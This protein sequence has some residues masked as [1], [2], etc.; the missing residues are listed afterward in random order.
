MSDPGQDPYERGYARALYDLRDWVR[1]LE[2]H[3]GVVSSWVQ[4]HAEVCDEEEY[5]EAV[6]KAH[7]GMLATIKALRG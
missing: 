3:Y 6:D 1:D 4:D 5:L 7:D 2:R